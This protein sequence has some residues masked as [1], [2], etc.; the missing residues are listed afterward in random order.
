M[1]GE[2]NISD[3]DSD[4]EEDAA[5]VDEAMDQDSEVLRSSRDSD[6]F[7]RGNQLSIWARMDDASRDSSSR[8][9]PI[10][11]PQFQEETPTRPKAS[12]RR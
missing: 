11:I 8:F 4:D 2:G 5:A 10:R 9:R 1:D 6:E 7:A 12:R 3:E